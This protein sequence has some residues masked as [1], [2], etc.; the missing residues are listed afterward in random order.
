[1]SDL[2]VELIDAEAIE[3][4]VVLDVAACSAVAV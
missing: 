3:F 1:M 2:V 4:V